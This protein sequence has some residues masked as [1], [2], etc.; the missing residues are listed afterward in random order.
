MEGEGRGLRLSSKAPHSWA[1]KNPP[2]HVHYRP[3]MT[4]A[5]Y[6]AWAEVGHTTEAGGD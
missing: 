3:R 6:G 2:R 1:V 5:L 4:K